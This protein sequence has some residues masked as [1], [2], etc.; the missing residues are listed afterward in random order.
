M[1]LPVAAFVNTACSTS[2]DKKQSVQ[3][4]ESEIKKQRMLKNY[5]STLDFKPATYN[6]IIKQGDFS[7]QS[8]T[9]VISQKKNYHVSLY[10][11]TFPLPLQKIHSWVLHIETTDGRPISNATVYMHG[12]MPVHRHGFP[13]KPRVKKKLGNGNYLVSGIKFSMIG[14]WE[15]RFSIEEPTIRDRAIFR[16]KI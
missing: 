8:A 3:A 10:S 4:D 12:G 5:T 9:T 1:V 7:P 16:I 13:V 14:E 15:I 6:N 2:T 11:K